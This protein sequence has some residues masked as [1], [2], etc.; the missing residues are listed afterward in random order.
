MNKAIE[1]TSKVYFFVLQL[2]QVKFKKR[3]KSNY[4]ITSLILV[5]LKLFLGQ[6]GE[7]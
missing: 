5:L 2:G 1:T 3:R 6:M 4:V 7:A